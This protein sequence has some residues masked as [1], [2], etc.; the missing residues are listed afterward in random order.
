MPYIEPC[1]ANRQLPKLLREHENKIL[2]FQTSGDVTVMKLMD[3]IGY[4]AG[5]THEMIL[6]MPT[7]DVQ[8]LRHLRW[9]VSRGWTTKATLLLNDACGMTDEE[10]I[11]EIVD[12]GGKV[13]VVY[14]R[15]VCSGLLEMQGKDGTVIV[16]GDMLMSVRA[17]LRLYSAYF[18]SDGE[19]VKMM[20][21]AVRSRLKVKRLKIED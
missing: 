21:G 6:M 4:M 5:D 2:T 14:D 9:F 3:A 1:C 18:G 17:G 13:L 11:A 7:V 12:T 15:M 20:D 10:I 16:Q 19:K 8:V